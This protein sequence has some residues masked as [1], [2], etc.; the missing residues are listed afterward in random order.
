MGVSDVSAEESRQVGRERYDALR[1][2]VSGVFSEDDLQVLDRAF[3]TANEAHA[4]QRRKSGEPYIIH[5]VAVATILA[6]L[7]MDMPSLA[8]ALLHD[9]VE[10]TPITLDEIRAS[11]GDEIALLVDGVTKIS[12]LQVSKEEQQNETLRKMLIAMSR[13]IRVIIIKLADR[14]HNIRTLQYVPEQKRRMTAKETLEIYAPIAHRLGIRAFKEELEDRSIRFLD[15]VAYNEI[16]EKLASQ[17]T[18]RK[19]FL[20]DIIARITARVRES[21]E[22]PE[23]DG[24]IKSVHGIYRKMF[25]RGKSFDEIYDIYAVRVIVDTVEDCYNCLGIMH[26]MFHSIPGRFKDYISTPKPNGYQSLHT[27]LIGREG[28]PFEV[29]I[30]TREMHKNAEYGI[31]AHWKYKM[32]RQDKSVDERLVWLRQ[33]LESQQE[34]GSTAEIVRDIKTDLVPEEVYALT[35]K[36]AVICLPVGSTVI[37]F[38]YAIHSAVGHRM[39][40]AKVD[41]RIVPIDYA[42]RTGQIVEILTSSQP[43]KGPSRD[44]LN[45]VKTSGARSKI[46]SWFKKERRD[47]NIVEGKAQYE[48]ELRKNGI[49]LTEQ[50][51]QSLLRALTEKHHQNSTDDFFAAIG[52]GGLSLQRLLPQIR[53]EANKIK[54][55]SEA[56]QS[57][58]KLSARPKTVSSNGVVVEGIDNCLVK[59]SKC[60]SP[61]PGDDIIGFITRGHGVSV[62]KRDCPNVPRS[63]ESAQEPERW[64]PVHWEKTETTGFSC[65]LIIYCVDR[66]SLLADVSVTLANMHVMIHSVSTRQLK[67]GTST[68]HMTIG[69]NN[70]D[71]LGGIVAKLE[72]VR[73]VMRVERSGA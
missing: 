55:E 17:A 2:S 15:P 54:Q 42:V 68:I 3:E 8:A 27:T 20:D 49:R 1:K 52:Y 62:H 48:R 23:V 19:A 58:F 29:Q 35:P 44:W 10:D 41:G 59:L 26:D 33:L 71:H 22:N 13:D 11:F 67:D 21:V 7:G 32:G 70:A 30:R 64:I 61:I 66:M 53:D 18:E 28:I 9:V 57:E 5:P 40:G 37:D 69:V 39:T 56:A 60:C 73:G 65:S 24:R 6:E 12:Q 72:K 34:A 51:A 45:I 31:A 43:G 47:E 14:V 63:I 16:E 25:Y 38:A 50:E 46:R 36:G 4:E